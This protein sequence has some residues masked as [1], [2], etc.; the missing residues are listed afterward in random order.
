MNSDLELDGTISVVWRDGATRGLDV[1]VSGDAAEAVSRTV[2][3]IPYESLAGTDWEF[4]GRVT[5]GLSG[6]VEEVVGM[7]LMRSVVV[8]EAGVRCVLVD[9]TSVWLKN[10]RGARVRRQGWATSD[11][12][13]AV[14]CS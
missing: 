5:R 11:D 1:R 12:T 7:S 10:P 8:S 9:D 13:I 14:A 4:D 2:L 3:R 6:E